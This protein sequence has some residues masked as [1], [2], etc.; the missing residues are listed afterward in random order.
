MTRQMNLS[1]SSRTQRQ[2]FT[3]WHLYTHA[4]KRKYHRQRYK[5]GL[6]TQLFYHHYPQEA[7]LKDRSFIGPG[8]QSLQHLISALSPRVSFYKTVETPTYLYCC[9]IIFDFWRPPYPFC[10]QLEGPNRQ[11]MR[12]GSY[13][14]QLSDRVS[15][16]SYPQSAFTVPFQGPFS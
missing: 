6:L 10:S 15:G 12:T 8:I 4:P 14:W 7:P 5:V 9:H 11:Q 13:S 2:L 3:L 16:Y 1:A